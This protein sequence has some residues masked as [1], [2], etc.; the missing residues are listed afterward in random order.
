MVQIVLGISSTN[1]GW[2]IYASLICGVVMF[3]IG[4]IL[5]DKYYSSDDVSE[6]E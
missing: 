4:L 6:A 5:G 1:P 3:M 2:Q